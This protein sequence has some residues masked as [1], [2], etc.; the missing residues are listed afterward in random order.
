MNGHLTHVLRRPCT[1]PALA[2]FAALTLSACV[3]END[4][5]RGPR[6]APSAQ[7]VSAQLELAKGYITSHELNRARGALEHALKLQ[8]TSWE[9]HDLMATVLL[10]DGEPLLAEKSWQT[11]IRY[12]GGARARRNYASFL[13]SVQ[14]YADACPLLAAAATELEYANRPQVY[15][16][17][18]TCERLRGNDQAAAQAF[19]RAIELNA[20][21]PE[22]QL[23]LAELLFKQK[24]YTQS[25]AAYQQYRS[26]VQ[27]NPRSLWLGVRLARAM[28]DVDAEAS[29][30]L[31]LRNQFPDS[32]EYRLLQENTP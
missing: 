30:A 2:L 24:E 4:D 18:G 12:G 3:M 15:E 23:E 8:S 22:A 29:R 13:M 32:A 20:K 10:Q 31:L 9:A 16:D 19:N 11:A 14:R 6:V 26:Q 25:L 21:Q 5:G 28:N 17:W 1:A 27:P 7:R